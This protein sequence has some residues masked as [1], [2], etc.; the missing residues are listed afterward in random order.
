MN[1]VLK[2]SKPGKKKVEQGEVKVEKSKVVKKEIKKEEKV[3]PEINVNTSKRELTQLESGQFKIGV[4]QGVTKNMG[5]FESYRCDFWAEKVVN[6]EN[7]E[8]EI[9]G[10]EDL[11]T[12]EIYKLC[13]Q[14]GV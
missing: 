9:Q 7:L 6:E 11:V 13:E 2:V 4:S 14:Q 8:E 1:K 3:K 5:N 10:L 12:K